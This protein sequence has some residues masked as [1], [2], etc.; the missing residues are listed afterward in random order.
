[1]TDLHFG[2][3]HELPTDSHIVESL[4]WAV[5]QTLDQDWDLIALGAHEQAIAHRIAFYLE[6]RFSGFHVDCEYNRQKHRTKAHGG[7]SGEDPK[8]MRPDI[9]VHRR[10][11]DTN[12]LALEMKANANKESSNDMG[13]L[14]ALKADK[15]GYVYKA[16]VFVKVENGINEIKDGKLTAKIKWLDLT[17][18]ELTPRKPI[19]RLTNDAHREEVKKIIQQRVEEK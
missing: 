10:N 7:E 15:Q 18:E 3:A 17:K 8:N 12:V 4:E 6:S 13:K 14:K 2:G 11:S 9:I 16:I 5:Q 19:T 1:M